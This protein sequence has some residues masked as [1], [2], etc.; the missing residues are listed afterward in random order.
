MKEIIWKNP[1]SD[2]F[3]FL[4]KY[5]PNNM[6]I[7]DFGCGNKQILD[8]CSPIEYL[9]IDITDDADLKIDLN[10]PFDLDKNFNLG[11]IL[12]LLEHID[13]PEFTLQNCI[14]YADAFIVLT[15]SAKMKAEWK[16]SFDRSKIENLLKKYF[17]TVEC[18][19][20]PRY[21]VSIARNKL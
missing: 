16:H 2:R 21:T 15:S 5:I 11:L 20:Y 8:Y 13:D 18:Y 4:E 9:G 10:K 3:L 17:E 6:S 19:S 12:G 1:W 14:R 7:V